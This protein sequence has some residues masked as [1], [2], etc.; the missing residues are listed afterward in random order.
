[1]S[2]EELTVPLEDTPRLTGDLLEQHCRI[3]EVEGTTHKKTT[4]TTTSV[5][6]K[7][8]NKHF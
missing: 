7:I 3:V 2:I 6:S 1:M 8:Y 4:T 5:A